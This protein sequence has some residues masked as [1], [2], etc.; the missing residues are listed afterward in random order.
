VSTEAG[1]LQT[2]WM[3]TQRTLLLILGVVV[4]AFIAALLAAVE[5]NWEARAAGGVLIGAIC[6]AY[7]RG[8]YI[9]S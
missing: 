4:I 6:W 3:R 1:E 9:P 2:S 8:W 7:W 5:L